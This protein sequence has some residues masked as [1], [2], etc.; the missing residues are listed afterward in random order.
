MDNFKN[1]A[2]VTVSGV[3]D[4]AAVTVALSTGHGAKLPAAPFNLSW[5]LASVYGDPSDDPNVEVVRCTNKVGDTLTITR[6]QESTAATAKNLV[7][8]YKMVAT[9][10]QKTVAELAPLSGTGSP[11]GVVAAEPGR[12]YTQTDGSQALWFKVTG[13]STTGWQ[14]MSKSTVG[15]GDPENAVIGSP[16]DTFLDQVTEQ[17]YAKKTGNDTNTGWV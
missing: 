6:A 5:W 7:G 8:T 10:T 13:V 4:A 15:S 11:E 3:Y 9:L 1:F 17:R 2:K 12:T 14:R 16:G